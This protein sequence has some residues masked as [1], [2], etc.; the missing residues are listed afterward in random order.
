M[1][2]F[3]ETGK[4][5][6]YTVVGAD[7]AS[8]EIVVVGD[9]VGVAVTGAPIGETITLATHGV[10][11]LPKASGA[12]AQGTKAYVKIEAEVGKSIVGAPSG[13]TFVGYVW[14]AAASGD[15]TVSVKLSI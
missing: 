12:L 7:V 15:A 1:K 13:N 4:T 3:I 9:M 6:D 5:I 2:N 10:Y 14:A 11:N 8:G